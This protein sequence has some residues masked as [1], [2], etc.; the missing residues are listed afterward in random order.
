M[1]PPSAPAGPRGAG[2]PWRNGAQ[3]QAGGGKGCGGGTSGG[4]YW[5]GGGGAPKPSAKW[6]CTECGCGCRKNKPQ[7]WHCKHCKAVRADPSPNLRGGAAPPVWPGPGGLPALPLRSGPQFQGSPGTQ[8]RGASPG[9]REVQELE[10]LVA[11]LERHG[12]VDGVQRYKRILEEKR[13][14]L[15]PPEAPLQQRVTQAYKDLREW[16]E[17]AHRECELYEQLQRDLVAQKTKVQEANEELGKAEMHHLDL[18][19]KLHASV[20][21]P[22]ARA[23]A[24]IDVSDIVTGKVTDIPISIASL[25][26][27]G[28]DD[29]YEWTTEERQEA[30]RR[31]EVLKD[32][33]RSAIVASFGEVQKKADEFKA[34]RLAQL[35]R[36]RHKRARTDGDKPQ[37]PAPRLAQAGLGPLPLRR[38][39][40]RARAAP[41]APRTGLLAVLL[42]V[43]ALPLMPRPAVL[44][45]YKSPPPLRQAWRLRGESF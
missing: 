17:M 43:R 14:Q 24:T 19:Q 40:L 21:N 39:R 30:T 26:D 6:T 4:T 33:L 2:Y 34:E 1:V 23:P 12:D 7:W 28:H 25:L 38:R 32:S 29:D 15:A 27:A 20:D 10:S 41:R 42:L 35:S 45:F 44:T 3:G 13:K 22:D 31:V 18:I 37:E 5:G 9:D 36:L 16:Q 8:P 11:T